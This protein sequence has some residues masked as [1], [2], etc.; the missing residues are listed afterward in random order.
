MKGTLHSITQVSL[1]VWS[2]VCPPE[3]RM[4]LWAHTSHWP[5]RGRPCRHDL[6]VHLV[7]T[8]V[9]PSPAPQ[10]ALSEVAAEN[11]PVSPLVS[12]ARAL[13]PSPHVLF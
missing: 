1:T 13:S 3:P 2:W 9:W 7:L 6:Q 4:K 5:I 11:L 10:G 12:S 8:R